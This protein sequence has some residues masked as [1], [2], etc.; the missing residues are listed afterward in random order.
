MP[1]ELRVVGVITRALFAVDWSASKWLAGAI[2]ATA[3]TP[4]DDAI[5]VKKCWLTGC[6]SDADS[7]IDVM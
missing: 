2:S 4:K 3:V 1:D 7:V 6:G 5:G